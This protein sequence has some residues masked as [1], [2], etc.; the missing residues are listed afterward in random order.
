MT[1]EATKAPP[2]KAR[3][4][5]TPRPTPTLA[6]RKALQEA[7]EEELIRWTPEQVVEKHLMPF[8]SARNIREKCYKRK[9]YYHNDGGR[10]TFTPGDLRKNAELGAVAPFTVAA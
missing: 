10:I 7:L 8:T 2:T 3:K 6:E 4:K 1:A 5:T 9:L